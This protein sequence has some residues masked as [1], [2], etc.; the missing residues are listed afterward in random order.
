MDKDRKLIYYLRAML[1]NQRQKDDRVY[2]A[3]WQTGPK[4]ALIRA[5]ALVDGALGCLKGKRKEDL[6]NIISNSRYPQIQAVTIIAFCGGDE[7]FKREL[8]EVA[9]FFS[10]AMKIRP[11]LSGN[12]L[13]EKGIEEGPLIGKKLRELK[14]LQARGEIRTEAQATSWLRREI[15][16]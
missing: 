1:F 16:E 5:A 9:T 14:V 2:W 4:K 13:R 7:E 3:W 12:D 10:Y 15:L 8:I 11:L 6:I